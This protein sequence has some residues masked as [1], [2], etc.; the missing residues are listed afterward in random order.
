MT[1]HNIFVC[2]CVSMQLSILELVVNT[3]NFHSF[4]YSH[5]MDR[6]SITKP[7]D[8]EVVKNDRT[9]H[10][11]LKYIT[12]RKSQIYNVLANSN[13]HKFFYMSCNSRLCI[14]IKTCIII[15][16]LYII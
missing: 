9:G 13:C 14:T 6:I 5:S 1:R 12:Y 7:V 11:I 2:N 16:I 8:M 3:F 10:K 15:E 4:I